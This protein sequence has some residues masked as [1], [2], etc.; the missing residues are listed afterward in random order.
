[1]NQNIL[2]ADEVQDDVAQISHSQKPNHIPE[3]TSRPS[4]TMTPEQLMH[5][6]QLTNSNNPSAEQVLVKSVQQQADITATTAVAQQFFTDQI[7]TEPLDNLAAI[8]S[9][10]LQSGQQAQLTTNFPLPHSENQQ[11][12]SDEANS[13]IVSS[14]ASS[15]SSISVMNGQSGNNHMDSFQLRMMTG[16]DTVPVQV[17]PGGYMAIVQEFDVSPP[18]NSMLTECETLPPSPP[19]PPQQPQEQQQQPPPPHQQQQQ[20]HQASV[21][22]SEDVSNNLDNDRGS[23]NS[24][25]E[26]DQL[27]PSTNFV[28]CTQASTKQS[29]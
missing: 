9:D 11:S 23:N 17:P 25:N 24:Q 16:T 10:T 22:V 28:T 13:E 1:M 6:L 5:T 8:A 26:N 7:M 4:Q 3:L 15:S 2:E 29:K 18:P 27:Q 21:I 20:T 19:P 14:T 12:F